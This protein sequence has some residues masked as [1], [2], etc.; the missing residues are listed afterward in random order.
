MMA[1]Q[2]Q[3]V[4]PTIVT[5][6]TTDLVVN[7]RNKEVIIPIEWKDGNARKFEHQSEEKTQILEQRPKK[8]QNL[9]EEHLIEYSN[10]ELVKVSK[11]VKKCTLGLAGKDS[12]IDLLP[13]K[14]GSFDIIVG[15]DWMSN[16]QATICCAEKI[17]RLALPN[18]SVLEVHG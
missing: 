18:G 11:V 9:K 12:S 6:V 15:M 1:Q 10:R 2:V 4:V 7:R 8:S 14:I 17:V 3:E 5:K 13:I 16:H